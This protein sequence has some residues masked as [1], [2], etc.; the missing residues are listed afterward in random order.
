[1]RSGFWK[2]MALNQRITEDEEKERAIL[3]GVR[4]GEVKAEEAGESLEELRSLAETAGAVVVGVMVQPRIRPDPATLL[5]KGKLAE[6]ESEIAEREA[7]LVIFDQELSPSQQR[8]L[9]NR[10]ESKILDRTALILD[11]FALHAHS[12]EGKAQVEMAQLRYRL[13]RLTGRGTELSRLGG[14]IGTRGPGETKLEADRRRINTRIKTLD[15]ELK[16]LSRIRRVKRKRREKRAVPTFALVGYTNAGK[17]SILNFFTGADVVVEDQLFSTLD[18]T[19]RRIML[20]GNRQAVL[21]DTVGFINHLPHQLVEAF[22]STLE[23]LKEADVLLHVIDGSSEN[24]DSRVEA[25]DEVLDEIEAGDMPA[26]YIINKADLLDEE[27]RR[28]VL[29]KL[30]FALLTSTFSGEGLDTLR[31]RMASALESTAIV[32]LFI[33]SEQG[34][35]LADIYQK[36]HVIEFVQ[37]DDGYEITA[38]LPPRLMHSYRRYVRDEGGTGGE[39]GVRHEGA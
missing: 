25:V 30:P 5:G 2:I 24:I 35:L 26:I 19:T 12:K 39:G 9:E 10:L 23:E 18:P 15:R 1:M 17:S 4:W 7:D 16:E 22:K 33:P 28:Q 27:T 6:L 14:G 38:T 3:V 21:S 13:T 8:N 37:E 32:R 36:G 11:I 34:E 20:P 29:K 31:E